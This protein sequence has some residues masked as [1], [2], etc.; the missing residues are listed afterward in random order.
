MFEPWRQVFLYPLLNGLILLYE[1]VA[2]GNLG[3]AVIEFTVLLRLLLFPLTVVSE[4][5]KARYERLESE[6]ERIAAAYKDDHVGMRERV[7]ELLKEN[8]INPWAKAVMIVIQG[9]VLLVIYQV[10]S[11]GIAASL[12]GLYSWVPAPV[13]PIEVRFFGTDIGAPSLAWAAAVGVVLYLAIVIDQR[14]HVNFLGRSDAVFR[15]AFPAFTVV[16]LSFLPMVKSLFVLTSILFSVIVSFVR[17]RL[18]PTGS[19]G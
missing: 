7:R 10:F 17:H 1:T 6:V 16:L 19:T 11:R 13:L 9:L 5:N 3:A 12:D 4:R 18:W 2:F 15:Y 14:K 8:R